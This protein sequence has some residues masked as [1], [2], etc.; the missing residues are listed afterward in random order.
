MVPYL[1][2][3]LVTFI[4]SRKVKQSESYLIPLWIFA[5]LF[6]G[7]RKGVGTDY[8]NYAD[9]YDTYYFYLELGFQYLADFLNNRR[10]PVWTLFLTIASLTY[11]FIYATIYKNKDIDKF[12]ASL[13]LTLCT[14]SFVCNGIRQGLAIAIFLFATRFIE[15]RKW[16]VYILLVLFASLF[17]TSIL[18]CLPIYFLRNKRLSKWSY[19]IIYI[20]SFIFTQMDLQSLTSPFMVFIEGNERYNNLLD[21]DLYNKSYFSLGVLSMVLNNIII[22]WL[23][24]KTDME[25]KRPLWFNLF[26]IS[27]VFVNMRVASPLFVRVQVIFGWFVYLL[28]PIIIETIKNKQLRWLFIWYFILYT[29]VTTIYYILS[30]ESKLYPYHDVVGIF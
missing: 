7:L 11:F 20:I 13:L 19:V 28:I 8:D 6:V 3:L 10:L 14:Y 18:L 1:L 23:S 16:Y 2:F 9:I 30:P 24:L 26:F 27:I 12:G 15:T 29:T 5:S 17:H 4:L 21:S 25:K 22:L